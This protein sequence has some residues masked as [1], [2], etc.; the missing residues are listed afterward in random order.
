MRGTFVLFVARQLPKTG[1]YQTDA[2]P[3]RPASARADDLLFTTLKLTR[4]HAPEGFHYAQIT[5]RQVMR[6]E[7]QGDAR[8]YHAGAALDEI[9][10]ERTI[11]AYYHTERRLFVCHADRDL[12]RSAVRA[13]NRGIEGFMSA[14]VGFD[15]GRVREGQKKAA[16]LGVWLRKPNDPLIRTQA[17]FGSNVVAFSRGAGTAEL[18]NVSLETTFRKQSLRVN[19]SR[20]GSVFFARDTSLAACLG[21]AVDLMNYQPLP[22]HADRPRKG[23]RR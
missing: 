11:M 13:L 16:L 8:F 3:S 9:V 20:G 5:H 6:S 4:T 12:A 23:T 19:V 10:L 1:V 14:P 18:S 22:S 15:P 7:Q 17:A 2:V 21:F